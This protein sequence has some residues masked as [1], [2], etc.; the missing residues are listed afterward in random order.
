MNKK[1]AIIAMAVVVGVAGVFAVLNKKDGEVS[2]KEE[3]EKVKIVDGQGE[4]EV[5]LNP[6]KVVAFDYGALDILDNMGV[7]V[8]GLPKES[9]PS[10]LE[11]YKADK[12]QDLGGLKEP[13]FEAIS[14]L[15]PELIII[16]GRQKDLYDK[17][18][19]I[20]PTIY[21]D[22]DGSKYMEDFTRNFTDLGKIF[23]KEDYVQSTLNKIDDEMVKLKDKVTS[24]KLN[25]ITVMANEGNLSAFSDKSRFGLLYNQLGFVNVDPNIEESSHG[26]QVTFEYI[27]EKNPDYIFVIDR[28]AAT[29]SDESAKTLFNNDLIKSTT[30]YKNNKIV[31]LNS[32]AW[33]LIAGGVTSTETMIKDVA[34]VIK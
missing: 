16:S 34:E 28:G 12:Y 4:K 27:V 29:G 10:S 1:V 6:T 7:E 32:Q 22:I 11:K 5:P 13:N 17:F 23:K 18:A 19:Q 24:E 30:A 3:I 2:A 33:Y 31:Y 15:K 26:Q 14:S 20:A 9:I 8:L 21:L 25:A